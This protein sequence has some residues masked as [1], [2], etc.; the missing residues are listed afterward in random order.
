ML[1]MPLFMYKVVEP[2]V[3]TVCVSQEWRKLRELGVMRAFFYFH[4]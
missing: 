2:H 3:R 1:H 4:I